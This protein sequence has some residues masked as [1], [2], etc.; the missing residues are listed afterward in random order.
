MADLARSDALFGGI[1]Q[2]LLK[3]VHSLSRSVRHNLLQ[4]NGRVFF[5]G[6]LVVI[7]Q[8]CNLLRHESK[9]LT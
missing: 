4:W 1:D 3:Q 6:D 7:W 9:N 5:E 8:L 2:K